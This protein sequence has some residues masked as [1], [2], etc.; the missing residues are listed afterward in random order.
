[1]RKKIKEYFPY[2]FWSW[3]CR[4]YN[5]LKCDS[6]NGFGWSLSFELQIVETP[7]YVTLLYMYVRIQTPETLFTA[8]FWCVHAPVARSAP[9]ELG[10]R[11][12]LVFSPYWSRSDCWIFVTVFSMR[13]GWSCGSNVGWRTFFS[14]NCS[15]FL[16]RPN[17]WSRFFLI[18][19][20]MWFPG[21]W[22]RF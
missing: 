15:N 1:M 8:H 14:E 17:F 7:K 18:Y 6:K 5:G 21:D 19:T 12:I 9:S 2:G 16:S 13:F 4:D 22:A 11:V 10:D 3:S 20:A